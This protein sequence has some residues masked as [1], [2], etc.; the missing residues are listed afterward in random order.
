MR[1]NET[2]LVVRLNVTITET[3][4][5]LLVTRKLKD[6]PHVSYLQSICRSRNASLSWFRFVFLFYTEKSSG[7]E[8]NLKQLCCRQYLSPYLAEVRDKRLVKSVFLQFLCNIIWSEKHKN[9][10]VYEFMMQIWNLTN[11]NQ[12]FSYG[13]TNRI[14]LFTCSCPLGFYIQAEKLSFN[15]STTSVMLFTTDSFK[16]FSHLS[17]QTDSNH[18][19]N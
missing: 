4:S 14:R 19:I 3:K 1:W 18:F 11:S 8:I 2:F 7:D 10:S 12:G 9:A 5:L 6:A 15:S 16:W 17:E 13:G